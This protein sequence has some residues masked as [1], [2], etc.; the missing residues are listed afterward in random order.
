MFDVSFEYARK[1][2]S[3]D[4]HDGDA[5]YYFGISA[6]QIGDY[7]SALDGLSLASLTPSKR[8]A[9]YTEIA[10]LYMLGGLVTY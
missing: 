8:T 6:M 3:I 1:A 10:K 5:N 2:I 4:T 9:A 7:T